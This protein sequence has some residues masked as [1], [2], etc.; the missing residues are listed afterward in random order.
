MLCRLRGKYTDEQSEHVAPGY[1]DITAARGR[2]APR[3]FLVNESATSLTYVLR[4]PRADAIVEGP[5][6]PAQSHRGRFSAKGG[7]LK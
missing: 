4:A 5:A 2:S 1:S 7:R 6:E 3:A